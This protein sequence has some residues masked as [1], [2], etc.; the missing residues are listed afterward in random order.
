MIE[1]ASE[2]RFVVSFHD[3]APHSQPD[4]AQFI[5]DMRKCGV[6]RLS[7][8]VV[9]NW[10][11]SSPLQDNPSFASW[12]RER[13]EEGHEIVLHGYTHKANGISGGAR[14]Q[15]MG[16]IYTAGE[17]EFY[18]L[19]RAE[20]ARLLDEGRRQFD[21]AGLRTRGFIAPAWLLS[22]GSRQ[23]LIDGGFDYTTYWG[24]FERFK[25]D[26][27]MYAPTLTFSC[28]THW[29]RMASHLW[30][31]AWSLVNQAA[32]VL[33]IAAHPVDLKYPTIRD[34]LKRLTLEERRS[35]TPATYADLIDGEPN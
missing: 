29:R 20:A 34:M 32:P 19:E 18:Q 5:D 4:C 17:G 26:E 35:R 31:R 10:Y 24:S 33:R 27:R 21:A 30:V 11:G 6:D 3:L 23:A 9:P 1:T 22:E 16:R 28:R 7:L 15:F 2:K 14:Q 8:L 12:L 25:R 13:A